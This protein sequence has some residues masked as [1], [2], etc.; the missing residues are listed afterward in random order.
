LAVQ[1][2]LK[3]ATHNC[4]GPKLTG[5]YIMEYLVVKVIGRGGGKKRDENEYS[6]PEI[7]GKQHKIYQGPFFSVYI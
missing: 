3:W 5:A 2:V 4:N 7:I 6:T 1:L